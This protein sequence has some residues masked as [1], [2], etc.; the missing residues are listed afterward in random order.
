MVAGEHFTTIAETLMK[1]R[2]RGFLCDAVL[3]AKCGGELKAHSALLAAVSP[4]FMTALEGATATGPYHLCFPEVELDVL[5]I[6]VHFVYT[7]RL[8]L[9]T[10]YSQME[11]L[12]K[13]FAKMTELGLNLQKLHGCEMTFV[14]H[15]SILFRK[16]PLTNMFERTLG[17]INSSPDK[18]GLIF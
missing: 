1:Y 10:V 5:K 2:Q 17:L 9:P 18:A 12:T 8:L 14:R 7:G 15:G 16:Y 3:V 13:L 6:A 11:Q 4:V